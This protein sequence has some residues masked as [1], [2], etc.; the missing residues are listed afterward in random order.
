MCAKPALHYRTRWRVIALPLHV[1]R[2]LGVLS[3]EAFESWLRLKCVAYRLHFWRPDIIRPVTQRT[4]TP[5][6]R[7]RSILTTPHHCSCSS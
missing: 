2:Q 5:S 6:D 1:P 4:P 3:D 7:S